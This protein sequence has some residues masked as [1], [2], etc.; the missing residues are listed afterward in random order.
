VALLRAHEAEGKGSR[1]FRWTDGQRQREDLHDPD[2]DEKV[3]RSD[4]LRGIRRS[5]AR[6]RADDTVEG[7][8][9]SAREAPE[10]C[11]FCRI[12]AV[13]SPVSKVHEDGRVRAL[14]TARFIQYARRRHGSSS[15]GGPPASSSCFSART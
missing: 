2:A 12:I 15:A 11:V 8:R 6:G 4:S 1:T 7:I 9:M 10:N 3:D 5:S 13:M 14:T